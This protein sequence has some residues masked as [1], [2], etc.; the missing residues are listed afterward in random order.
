MSLRRTGPTREQ[1]THIQIVKQHAPRVRQTRGDKK[2]M[3]LWRRIGILLSLLGFLAFFFPVLGQIVNIANVAAMGGFLLLTA[4]FLCWPGF[5]RLLGWLWSRRWGKVLLLAVG[6]GGGAM[7]LALAVLFCLVASKLRAVPQE[8]CPTI[9]VL[10][11]QVRN[12]APSLLLRYRIEAAADYLR[13]HPM[14]VAILSGGQGEGEGI[15]EAECMYRELTA[16]GIEANRLHLED[17]SRN[18]LENLRFSKELMEREG[19]RGPV[20]VVSSDF[21]IY[22]ALRIAEDVGLEANG[23]AAKSRY[24]FSTPTYIL[25]EAMAMV[26]YAFVT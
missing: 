9:I 14:S 3:P 19:L 8:P 25:R 23:L 5:L 18:T 21:H 1:Q 12:T 17:R 11:C 10:G 4:I 24:H 16:M 26:Q 2:R 15:S 13:E 22:R 7:V 6:I 20:A